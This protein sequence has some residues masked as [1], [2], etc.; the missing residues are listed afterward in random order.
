MS[1]LQL[2]LNKHTDLQL[3]S[4]EITWVNFPLTSASFF[5]LPQPKDQGLTTLVPV[6]TSY[7][8]YSWLEVAI[9]RN[10]LWRAR[11][12]WKWLWWFKW[13]K[14]VI[15]SKAP[16]SSASWPLAVVFAVQVHLRHT[17]QGNPP[18]PVVWGHLTTSK[19]NLTPCP[20]YVWI[21][22]KNHGKVQEG[23]W[24]AASSIP[25]LLR[26]TAQISGYPLSDVL[27]W[28]EPVEFIGG[29]PWPRPLSIT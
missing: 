21:T 18:L 14:F 4:P 10:S 24:E 13:V 22:A 20:V 6:A 15:S 1:R 2:L 28:V 19:R 9:L 5:L 17:V 8:T 11:M 23:S 12:L 3:R 26:S 7:Q 29:K 27:G 16:E 25:I